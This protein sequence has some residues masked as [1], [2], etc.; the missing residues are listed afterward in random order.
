MTKH[1]KYSKSVF[2]RAENVRTISRKRPPF[3]DFSAYSFADILIWPSLFVLCHSL[4]CF[5]QFVNIQK[6]VCQ[7]NKTPIPYFYFNVLE[8]ITRKIY[9]YIYINVFLQTYR[10][11]YDYVFLYINVYVFQIKQIHMHTHS[12]I[13]AHILYQ[14]LRA[15]LAMII[16]PSANIYNIISKYA[17]IFNCHV[18]TPVYVYIQRTYILKSTDI[19]AHTYP[20]RYMCS[21]IYI[22]R[23]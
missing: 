16:L 11:I 18:C 20:H 13:Y 5:G 10:Q 4:F 12:Q 19:Y 14:L 9:L 23:R 7:M 3:S 17:I 8:N 21:C 15:T 1:S 2:G 22:A 6:H